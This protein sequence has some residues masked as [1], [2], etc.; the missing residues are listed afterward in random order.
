MGSNRAYTKRFFHEK[1]NVEAKITKTAANKY[2]ARITNKGNTVDASMGVADAPGSR[3]ALDRMNKTQTYLSKKEWD[4]LTNKEK[5]VKDPEAMAQAAI[6]QT[7]LDE[8]FE[9][10]CKQQ[11]EA[12]T[13]N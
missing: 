5:K 9:Q 12:T 13:D 4:S 1:F 11:D 7:E 10:W 8:A 6:K 3:L 2:I